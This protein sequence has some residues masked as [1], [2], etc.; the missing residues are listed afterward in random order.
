M[1]LEN[2]IKLSQYK[3]FPAENGIIEEIFVENEQPVDY[4]MPLIK[5]RPVL[6][7]NV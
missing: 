2:E 3:D 5:I 6:E 1:K 4:G 7:E